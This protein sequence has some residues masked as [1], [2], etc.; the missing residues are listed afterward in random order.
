[1]ERL[2]AFAAAAELFP[3]TNIALFI[4]T[5]IRCDSIFWLSESE[6]ESESFVARGND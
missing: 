6:S 5:G 2:Y 4:V 3:F 1:V